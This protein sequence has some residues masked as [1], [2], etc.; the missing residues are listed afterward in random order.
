MTHIVVQLKVD[1][2]REFSSSVDVLGGTFRRYGARG[3]EVYRSGQDPDAVIMVFDWDGALNLRELLRRDEVRR[4][5]NR[6]SAEPDIIILG[7]D[8]PA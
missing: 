7:E 3:I 8:Q 5:I 4:G 2:F 1:D 6:L